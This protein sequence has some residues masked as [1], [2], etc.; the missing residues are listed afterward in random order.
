M[1]LKTIMHWLTSSKL[2]KEEAYTQS[3]IR[4]LDDAKKVAEAN[5]Q[6]RKSEYSLQI[7][8]YQEK[9]NQQ[10][11]AHIDFMNGQL[12][13][14]MGYLPK[15]NQFQNFTFTC[16]D[17][18]LQV[19]LCQQEINIVSQRVSAID[20]TIGL[21]DAYLIEIDK[22]SQ[23]QDRHDWRKLTEACE[24]TVT[25][26]F[27]DKTIERIN[28]TSKSN[29]DELK[30][31]IKRLKSHRNALYKQKTN[32]KSELSN[33][34]DR[35]KILGNQHYGNKKELMTMYNSCVENW[36][37]IAKNFE[38]Y[39]AFKGSELKYANEWLNNLKDGGT[40]QEI[41]NLIQ[42]TVKQSINSA[43]ENH[44]ELEEKRKHYASKVTQAHERKDYPT[45]F[46]NDKLMRD[47][48]KRESTTAWEDLRARYDAQSF[49]YDRRNEINSYINHIKPLHPDAMVDSLCQIL[50][51]EGDFDAWQAFGINTRK[52]KQLYWEKKQNR[53]KNATTN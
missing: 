43:K 4:K 18:W 15:L 31:E 13:I 24:I 41:K 52:E 22:L 33:L 16:I 35:K 25:N 34:K 2:E 32:L 45:T 8:D 7:Q 40:L 10:L 5:I 49:L 38:S 23:R 19:D 12:Q 9:R 44:N 46:A 48:F 47:R 26:V 6:S 28:R 53:I 3:L 36:N 21:I 1:F 39:Y 51:T 11:K 30:Q 27:V 50:N 42:T 37:Q 29:N 20:T 14:T 17:S